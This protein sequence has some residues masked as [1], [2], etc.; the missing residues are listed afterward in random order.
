MKR[1]LIPS[2]L[3]LL[4]CPKNTKDTSQS[5]I[6]VRDL[7]G[8]AIEEGSPIAAVPEASAEAGWKMGAQTQVLGPLTVA[9]AEETIASAQEKLD[10]C[11]KDIPGGE[12][13]ADGLPIRVMV[14]PTGQVYEAG[15]RQFLQN[16]GPWV[17][18]VISNLIRMRFP[19]SDEGLPVTIYHDL[20][21][22]N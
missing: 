10:T 20:K 13:F 17:G 7:A 2:L 18:C 5:T 4:G 19:P 12:E 22:S 15:L 3:V 6:V 21:P 1:L 16:E 8:E 9:Q 14:S 11:F